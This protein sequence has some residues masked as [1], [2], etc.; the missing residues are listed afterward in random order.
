MRT[1]GRK[2]HAFA[3]ALAAAMAA[4]IGGE[5]FAQAGKKV[6]GPYL[7]AEIGYSQAR[8]ADFVEDNPAAPD[9]FLFSASG[10]C[11]SQLNNLGSTVEYGIG[12]G[13][14]FN[15]LFRLD[16]S[17]G[18]RGNYNLQGW[19]SAGTYFD[20]KV[21]SDSIMLT[22]FIDIPYKIA[23]RVQPYVGIAVGRSRNKMDSINWHD[24]GPPSSNGTLNGASSKNSTA[25]QFT[26]GAAIS[27]TDSWILD[28]GYRY[29]DMGEFQ[30]NAG[31]DQAGNFNGTGFTS[32]AT[33]NLRANEFFAGVRYDF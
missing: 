13:Y 5:A 23:D 21:S 29:S 33:G 6:A 7:R 18:S 20:P 9:C 8:D 15:P 32:S 26:L 16:L 28:L 25:W 27:L 10:G 19:D 1:N 2:H 12:I 22:A 31:P 30:K 14:R 17:Y 24:P 11:G 3:W 4:T